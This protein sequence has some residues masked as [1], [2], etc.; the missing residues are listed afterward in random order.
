MKTHARYWT[1]LLLVL[2]LASAVSGAA[3]GL[4]EPIRSADR[5]RIMGLIEDQQ[6]ARTF[7]QRS[8]HDCGPMALAFALAQQRPNDRAAIMR[9][10]LGREPV[11]EDVS[12]R[13]LSELASE[14]EQTT[15]AVRA[16]DMTKLR[17]PF[18]ARLDLDHFVAVYRLGPDTV[19]YFDPRFGRRETVPRRVFEARWDRHALVLEKVGRT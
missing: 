17:L 5:A 7:Q 11:T 4:L 2:A 1:G 18:V 15:T 12:L 14:L 8:R 10:M 9:A 16:R 3:Y 19:T 6:L 13:A